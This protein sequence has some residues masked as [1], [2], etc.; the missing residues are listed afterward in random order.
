M[1]SALPKLDS[2]TSHDPG[3]REESPASAAPW[4]WRYPEKHSSDGYDELFGLDGAPRPAWKTLV[5][6]LGG[7]GHS[8]LRR[9]WEQARALLHEH[10][11]SYDAYGD[12]QGVAR[13]WNLSPIP[14]LVGNEE[15]S[16]I[17]RGVAQRARLLDL[18]LADL[19]GP[20]GLLANGDLPPEVAFA[21]PAFLRPCV[22][23]ASRGKHHLTMY[24]AD[25]GRHPDGRILVLADRT[26]AP[27]G[28]GYALENRIVL[29]RS[30]PE[31]FRECHV[32]RLALYFRTMRDTL[33]D[34]APSNRDNP[35]IVL[36]TPGPYHATYFEQAFLA[37]Y[38]GLTLVQGG[39]LAV[40]DQRVFLKTL[41][42]LQPVD[43]IVRRVRDDYCD[44]LELRPDSTLG[45]PG[46]MEAW[47]AGSVA[48]A[49]PIG[50]GVLQTPLLMAF[51]PALCRKLLGEEL[52]LPS[53]TTHWCGH[54]E[55]LAF[56]EAHLPDLV[57]RPAFPRGSVPPVFAGRLSAQAVE[58]LR[59]RIRA[60]PRAYVAHESVL[61]STVPRLVG[62]ALA[63]AHLWMRA[64]AV[65]SGDAYR[66]MPG[67]LS[68]VGGLGENVA[69]SLR[70]GGESRD[71][72]V[73]AGG[74]VSTF[75]MLRPPSAPPELSRGGGDLPSRVADNFFWLG[76]YAERTEGVARL[77][78]AIGARLSDLSGSN[79]SDGPAELDALFRGLEGQTGVGAP[80]RGCSSADGERRHHDEQ[81]LL[82]SV[83]DSRPPGTLRTTLTSTYRVARTLRD[84]LSGDAWRALAQ[85][86]E[87]A[88]QAQAVTGPRAIGA[89]LNLLN[90]V[91][92]S[93]SAFGGLAMDSMSRGQAWRF[94]DAGRRLER[95]VHMVSLL[96]STLVPPCPQE[97][98][99]L[100]ALLEVADSA[101]T[102]RRRYL[103]T[104]QVAPVVD[105]LLT[106]ETNP[107]SVLFQVNALIDHVATLPHEARTTGAPR[108]AQ[109][110]LLIAASTELK[111]AEVTDICA[112][113]DGGARRRLGALLDRLGAILPE[114]SDVLSSVYL[115]HAVTSRS[116]NGG[117]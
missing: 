61:L 75:T 6:M 14:V 110:K 117:T 67:A 58:E 94:L 86:H 9:R 15:W 29:S 1:R 3:V 65:V 56:V 74:P 8:E 90:R 4:V 88:Q 69:L 49:N 95:A 20:Q 76:R 101:M 34:L 107:R 98:P 108:T 46:L 47:R 105:L 64:Y 72:W 73:L 27:S 62:D 68:R 36:L 50:S 70:P 103:A 11:V 93:F 40:R 7:L 102:Y 113:E 22:G 89:L 10:G 2:V 33:R 114:L 43:V 41:G 21:D 32:D 100:E 37:Q 71:T 26:R 116:A 115:E 16:R 35:R 31:V 19:Y 18:V 5:S 28:A 42:R 109:E 91:V 77:A 54:P 45:V 85:V 97:G 79:D 55:S 63:R 30:L 52:A 48:L 38:L 51:L 24:A 23:V 96:R 25:L 59:A 80:A 92:I 81:W 106:D 82:D 87:D 83:F 53:L 12:P 39:D 13:P 44:P 99:L 84:R 60:D 57:V 78:R 111:L 17:A 66:V 112:T 104:L